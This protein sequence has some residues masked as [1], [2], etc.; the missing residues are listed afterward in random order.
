MIF[1]FCCCFSFYF[2]L[3]LSIGQCLTVFLFVSS[4]NEANNRLL[5]VTI[6]CMETNEQLPQPA[7]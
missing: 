6:I 3:I 2:L 4:C 5:Y 1:V 7:F